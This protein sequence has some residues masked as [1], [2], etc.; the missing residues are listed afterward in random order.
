MSI[1]VIFLL[2]LLA[3]LVH[4]QE[5][6]V[7]T[8]PPQTSDTKG[9]VVSVTE[10]ST[11]TTVFCNV[12]YIG[13]QFVASWRII[14]GLSVDNLAFN[15]DGTGANAD[16]SN[17]YVTGELFSADTTRTNLSILVFDSSLDMTLLQ[18]GSGQSFPGDFNLGIISKSVFQL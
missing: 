11:N 5:V 10:N 1:I 18:C 9:P 14:K 13:N 12:T 4:C 7:I 17:F 3:L 2:C 16:S 15:S 8:V 6:D